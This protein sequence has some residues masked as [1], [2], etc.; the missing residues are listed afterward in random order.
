MK[1]L[2]IFIALFILS[3]FTF[4][5]Q[6]QVIDKVVAIVGSNMVTLSDIEAQYFQ[7]QAQGAG[8]G[9]ELKCTIYENMILQKLLVSQA[10]IDSVEITDKEVEAELESRLQNFIRQ[11]GGVPELEAYFNKSLE[12][13]KEDF[14][15][16][17]R[18]QLITSRMQSTI[19]GD[20]K[21][22]PAEVNQF[23]KDLPKDSLPL[24]DAEFE[25]SQLS[26]YPEITKEQIKNVYD[27][28]EDFKA[29][30][31][32]GKSKFATLAVLYS[33][34]PGSAPNGGDL[35]FVSR[36]ELVPEFAAAAFNLKPNEISKVVKTDFG[37]HII[38]MI[39]KRGDQVHVAHILIKPEATPEAD[40]KAE[41]KLDSV[42]NL[43][44]LDSLT[45]EKAALYY[46]QDKETR[47]NS[48]IVVNP[49]TGSTKFVMKELN[50]QDLYQLKKMNVG[51][52]SNSIESKDDKG[53]KVYKVLK[54]RSK[55]E[56]HIAN[57][58]DDYQTI[59]EMALAKKKDQELYNWVLE[60]Q[61]SNYI[62]IDDDYKACNF[63]YKG[64]LTN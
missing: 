63:H 34:D 7:Y 55:S 58:K 28:L 12:E 60:K 26:I 17:V 19:L 52:M 32:S 40:K 4:A 9:P 29:R 46:S 1:K 13:I 47:L 36:G 3:D 56:A 44:R 54:L 2:G 15:D 31:E 49:N 20:I 21:V 33:Q 41:T 10:V 30:V 48:G 27:K 8:A 45:F 64:W 11:A 22:T 14:R 25:Y 38:Q 24:I 5:Q 6:K 18:D 39:E 62:K 50:S 51:E 43:I 53:A 61:K 23:Y 57:L 42:A 37:Y 16:D 35:G 59:Q